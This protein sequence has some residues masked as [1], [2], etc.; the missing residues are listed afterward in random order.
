[1]AG[2]DTP[3]LPIGA[4][5][6]SGP[7]SPRAPSPGSA[8]RRARPPGQRGRGARPP[9]PRGPA[10]GAA[11]RPWPPWGTRAART[12][13]RRYAAAARAPGES[14][15]ENSGR[16]KA[17][18]ASGTFQDQAAAAVT[19]GIHFHDG[20]SEVAEPSRD[21]PEA[22]PEPGDPLRLDLDTRALAVMAH[23]HVPRDSQ[24]PQIGLG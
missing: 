4:C 13:A 7:R 2:P 23:P 24:L 14:A 6:A 22:L 12:R 10:S 19:A 16:R 11:G 18:R 9:A 20:E 3:R 17:S 15:R 8:A 1:C 5:S 21:R